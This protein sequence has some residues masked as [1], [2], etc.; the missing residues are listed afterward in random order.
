MW[1]CYHTRADRRVAHFVAADQRSDPEPLASRCSPPPSCPMCCLSTLLYFR[2][3]W[4][5]ACLL[6][7][8]LESRRG[9]AIGTTSRTLLRSGR[10]CIFKSKLAEICGKLSW[11]WKIFTEKNTTKYVQGSPCVASNPVALY[12]REEDFLPLT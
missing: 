3:F 9:Q 10:D 2:N 12:L 5:N 11:G 7:G 4:K 8:P 6:P 1:K